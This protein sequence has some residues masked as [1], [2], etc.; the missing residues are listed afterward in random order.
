MIVQHSHQAYHFDPDKIHQMMEAMEVTEEETQEMMA[1]KPQ[2]WIL[3]YRKSD[4][5][6][7]LV[8]QILAEMMEVEGVKVDTRLL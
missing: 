3:T 5:V 8:I 4:L 6:S 2:S 1:K 7:H